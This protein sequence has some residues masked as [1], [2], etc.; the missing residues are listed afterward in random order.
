M[1]G[2]DPTLR[3]V[4]VVLVHLIGPLRRDDVPV[5]EILIVAS[6]KI[7]LS[8][9]CCTYPARSQDHGAGRVAITIYDPARVVRSRSKKSTLIRWDG[10][11][12]ISCNYGDT[13]VLETEICLAIIPFFRTGII[14]RNRHGIAVDQRSEERR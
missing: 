8:A 1:M 7:K 9:R 4:G 3:V 14:V 10:A 12:L 6:M 2:I 13:G 11:T 5:A